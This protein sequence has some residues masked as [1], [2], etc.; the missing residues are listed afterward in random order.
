MPITFRN[1]KP[2]DVNF[3]SSCRQHLNISIYGRTTGIQGAFAADLGSL[4]VVKHA[5][6]M[7]GSHGDPVDRN[8]SEM[9]TDRSLN[10]RTFI[11]RGNFR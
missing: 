2:I 7:R 9:S 4:D 3:Y 1:A 11:L 10:Y 5:E 6:T 8:G